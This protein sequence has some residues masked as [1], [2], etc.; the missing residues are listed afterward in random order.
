MPRISELKK[1]QD[2]EIIYRGV[3]STRPPDQAHFVEVD[4]VL[5]VTHR[6]FHDRERRI[7]FRRALLCKRGASDLLVHDIDGVAETTA[8]KVRAFRKR[9]RERDFK[10]EV[11]PTPDMESDPPIIGHVDVRVQ[12]FESQIS[13]SFDNKMFMVLASYLE[14]IV[15]S[16]WAIAPPVQGGQQQGIA[17]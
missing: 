2:S 15:G 12:P 10:G 14:Q 16:S 6:A 4:G 13:K 11:D 1:V 3:K 9:E 7:S 17:P 5:R 8:G